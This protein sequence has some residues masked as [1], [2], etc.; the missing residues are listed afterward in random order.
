M[1]TNGRLEPEV[2]ERD[3]LRYLKLSHDNV[4]SKSRK[5][6]LVMARQLLIY[7]LHRYT[8]LTHKELGKRVG[9]RDHTT[10]IHSL[11]T[12]KEY[13]SVKDKL[14]YPMFSQYFLFAD[15]KFTRVYK[16]ATAHYQFN[17]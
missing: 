13:L 1:T 10:V 6:E 8:Y 7:A 14:Y 5:N 17:F 4:I 12:V 3:V 15:I 9:R 11:T 2:V 16:H